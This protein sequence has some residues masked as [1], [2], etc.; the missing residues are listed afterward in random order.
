MPLPT[1]STPEEAE[2]INRHVIPSLQGEPPFVPRKAPTLLMGYTE[3]AFFN[4]LL[5]SLRPTCAIEI[6]TETGAT[7]ALM[8]KYS[9]QVVS[10]DIDPGVKEQLSPQFRNVAFVTGS[11]QKLLRQVLDKIVEQSM[12]VDFVFID[13]DHSAD[14]VRA[15]I[16]AFLE[17]H[18][19]KQLVV[20]MHDSFNP[21]CRRGILA[22]DWASSPF[23][24]FVDVDFVPGV[25]HS[26]KHVH[27]QMWGGLGYALFL[28][29]PRKHS[30]RVL[31]S[32]QLLYEA[33]I[34]QSSHADHL[35]NRD[36]PVVPFARPSSL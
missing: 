27:R 36:T 19:T 25:L 5:S 4:S 17:Y 11:S 12:E 16:E 3:I 28:P 8:A 13:G 34:L 6:G 15:D 20:V 7:L 24:H 22:A 18:P 1:Q 31:A 32:H 30:L 2:I 9:K 26:D 33:A 10:I 14:G 23:C 29:E 21:E 35:T